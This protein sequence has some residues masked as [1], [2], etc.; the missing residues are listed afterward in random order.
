MPPRRRR[1]NN[2]RPYKLD[3]TFPEAIRFL[4]TAP[5]PG[6]TT[7]T[8]SGAGESGSTTGADPGP[9]PEASESETRRTLFDYPPENQI[10]KDTGSDSAD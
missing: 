5:K 1:S 3:M 4:A 6:A 7:Q 2:E 9:D 10:R 8:G